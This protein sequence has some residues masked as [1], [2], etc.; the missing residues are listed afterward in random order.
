MT[1]GDLLELSRRNEE[2]EKSAG[3]WVEAFGQME[4]RAVDAEKKLALAVE[5][6]QFYAS[7]W[8]INFPYD[9]NI[10]TILQAHLNTAGDIARKALAEIEE[11]DA[12]KIRALEDSINHDHF[13]FQADE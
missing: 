4:H 11:I 9:E 6:L 1:I 7:P 12:Q 13:N 8:G 3:D 2:L 5:A 10:N